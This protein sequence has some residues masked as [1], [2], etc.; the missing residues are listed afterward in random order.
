MAMGMHDRGGWA[1][2]ADTMRYGQSA[3]S[4][5]PTGMIHL[6][7]VMHVLTIM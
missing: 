2:M 3:G 5:H 4:M 6:S 1:C 7:L